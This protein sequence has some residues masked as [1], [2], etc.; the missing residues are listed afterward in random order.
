MESFEHYDIGNLYIGS[1][2]S[3]DYDRLGFVMF[4]SDDE[5]YNPL[6][7]PSKFI[8][9]VA[10]P[11]QFKEVLHRVG[12]TIIPTNEGSN[13]VTP[14]TSNNIYIYPKEVYQQEANRQGVEDQ[15]YEVV[16]AH[17]L[18]HLTGTTGRLRRSTLKNYYGTSRRK[19]ECV[20]IIGSKLLLENLGYTLNSETLE[21]YYRLL[22]TWTKNLMYSQIV[23]AQK[24]AEEAVNYLLTGEIKWYKRVM[25]K[26]MR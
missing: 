16:L 17:E 12:G 2:I 7:K 21:R 8:G 18:I 15:Q 20:A 5:A 19:E 14:Y 26:L 11:E 1:K 9:P 23:G 22:S 24:K 3:T 13:H 6:H 25:N 4:L 10:P